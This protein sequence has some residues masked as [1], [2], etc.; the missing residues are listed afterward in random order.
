M[1]IFE[2]M[3]GGPLRRFVVL[4]R[5]C[6]RRKEAAREGGSG[7][8]RLDIDITKNRPSPHFL[9]MSGTFRV[10]MWKATPLIQESLRRRVFHVENGAWKEGL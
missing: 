4:A 2:T 10:Y 9:P 5:L 3:G 1:Y 8:D 7:W 6:S